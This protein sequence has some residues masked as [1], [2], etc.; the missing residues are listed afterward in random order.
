MK[1]SHKKFLFVSTTCYFDTNNGASVACRSLM[2]CLSRSGRIAAA[3]T[4]T[5]FESHHEVDLAEFLAG[6]GICPE[7]GLAAPHGVGSDTLRLEVRG[8]S[9]RLAGSQGAR[10]H[11]PDEPER[12]RFLALF[13]EVTDRFSPDVV[14]T[15]GGDTLA[16]QIRAMARAKGA[17]VV[18]AL[19]N[20][21]YRDLSAFEDVDSIFVPSRFAASFY[22]SKLGLDCHPLPNLIDFDRARALTR[23]PSYV[24]FINPSYEKG[25]FIFARIADELGRRRP[26]IPLLVVEGRGS[27]RI[28]VNCG[29][30][31]RS[32]GNVN[33]VD[34]VPDVRDVWGL[35]KICLMPSVWWE[36]QGLVA[37]E[38]MI[39]GI[40]V[41]GADR[42]ALPETLGDGGIVL[43][44]PPRLTPATS[45]LPT[46][47][48]V[49]P[50]VKAIIGL[51]DDPAWYAE[52]GR[53][54]LAET[55]RWT[56]EVLEPRYT[57]FFD[58][59]RGLSASGASRGV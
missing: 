17:I 14:V 27:E 7:V 10:L 36:S 4:G 54:A 42:G 38:A 15:Y 44:I 3:L 26:D 29:L 31:L 20:F 41:L 57:R 33:M 49:E 13:E 28:L 16:R 43:P 22:R 5:V 11:D 24:T 39:N 52:Q 8:V 25:V 23:N 59:V 9:V 55:A 51:W 56:P 48:E 46:A 32:H 40:P 1:V 34:H 37:I 19:H 47:A 50:W 58:E 12:R 6:E 30:D 21:N 2:E 45:E 35:T 53:R 18:F